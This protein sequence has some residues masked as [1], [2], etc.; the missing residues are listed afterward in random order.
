LQGPL[1][2]GAYVGQGLKRERA[3]KGFKSKNRKKVG[4]EQ[5]VPSIILLQ[6]FLKIFFVHNL[7]FYYKVR[8]YIIYLFLD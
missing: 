6:G 5:V 8:K 2:Q 7:W 4:A 1:K 3:I